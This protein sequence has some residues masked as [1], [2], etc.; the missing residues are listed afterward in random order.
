MCE[1]TWIKYGVLIQGKD[2]LLCTKCGKIKQN[3]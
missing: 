1:H 3:E 2:Y